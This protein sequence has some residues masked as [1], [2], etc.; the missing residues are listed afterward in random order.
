MSPLPRKILVFGATGGT[1]QLIVAQALARGHQVTAFVRDPSRLTT[2]PQLIRVVV[3]S[4]TGDDEP[5]AAAIRG[6]DVVIRRRTPSRSIE[7]TIRG[8]LAAIKPAG[9]KDWPR[10]SRALP[11]ARPQATSRPTSGTPIATEV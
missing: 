1:G 4:V 5:V 11:G 7:R 8:V 6:Q 2:A 3:G 10:L 9:A